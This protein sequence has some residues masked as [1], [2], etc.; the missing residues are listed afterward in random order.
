MQQQAAATALSAGNPTLPSGV[1]PGNVPATGAQSPETSYKNRRADAAA[2]PPPSTPLPRRPAESPGPVRKKS[3]LLDGPDTRLFVQYAGLVLLHPYLPAFFKGLDLMAEKEFKDETCRHRAIHL[4]HYLATK[5]SGL[6]E[7]MLLLPKLLCGM[8]FEEPME[9]YLDF[10]E[11][12]T[13]ECENL[14]RAVIQNWGAL[15]KSSPDALR[16]GFLRR[17]GKLEKQPDG[18]KLTVERQ[19]L[20]ILLGKLPWGLGIV[21]LPWMPGILRVEWG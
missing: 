5:E 21:K 19:T 2:S 10:S 11:T 12:E 6:P 14:L 8:P 1:A 4:L 15:G 9:R 3:P 17:D 16:E 20:D 7:F 18:W 13:A